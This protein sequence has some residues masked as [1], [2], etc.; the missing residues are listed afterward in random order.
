MHFDVSIIR[1]AMSDERKEPPEGAQIG[2]GNRLTLILATG[3]GAGYLRP[4]P[5]TWGTLVALPLAWALQQA[6]LIVQI[7][8][9]LAIFAIGIPLSTR[10][11]RLMGKKDPGGVVIDEIAAVQCMYW[12]VPCTWLSLAI[13]FAWFR[14][15][16]ITKPW[17][18]SWLERL[19]DGLGIMADDVAAAVYAGV[20][21]WLTMWL[22]GSNGTP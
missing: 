14:L 4:A 18:V 15:F 21:L 7:P 3:L 11:A 2:W 10:A 5:G 13:G 1:P 9:S 19:P 16:D 12:F 8:V 22:I 6:S 17:P 20:A